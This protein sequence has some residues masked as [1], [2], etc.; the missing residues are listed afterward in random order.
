[1]TKRAPSGKN[2]ANIEEAIAFK[3]ETTPAVLMMVRSRMVHKL[4]KL[5]KHKQKQLLQLSWKLQKQMLPL[6][7]K[8]ALIS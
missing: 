7:M 1:M 2:T 8:P 6:A 3:N 5:Q 4:Q